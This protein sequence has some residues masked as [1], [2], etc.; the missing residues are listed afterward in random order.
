MTNTM[1]TTAMTTTATTSFRAGLRY[2]PQVAPRVPAN[3]VDEPYTRFELR[4]TTPTIGAEVVGIDLTAL[5]EE[6]FADLHRAL[7]EWKVLFVRGSG[8]DPDSHAALGAR[9]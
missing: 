7:L 9:W 8:L 3:W 4:P 1:T 6:T 2:G 5:D